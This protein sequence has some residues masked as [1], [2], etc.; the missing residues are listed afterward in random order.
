M[1]DNYQDKIEDLSKFTVAIQETGDN[2]RILGTGVVVADNGL[3]LI[4]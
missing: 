2:G 1:Q 4:S 3:I